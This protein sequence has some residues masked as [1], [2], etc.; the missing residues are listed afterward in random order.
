MEYT[1]VRDGF[2]REDSSCEARRIELP[3]VQ[4]GLSRI[5]DTIIDMDQVD[6][7]ASGFPYNDASQR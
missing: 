4:P 7:A 6:D 3:T 2:R 1:F 5:V